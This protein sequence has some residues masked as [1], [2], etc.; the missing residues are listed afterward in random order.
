M[1]SFT[2]CII[3]LAARA[4][5]AQGSSVEEHETGSQDSGQNEIVLL[6]STDNDGTR[7]QFVVTADQLH[8][9]PE[10]NGK[11]EPPL[12]MAEAISL[13]R[14]EIKR[15]QPE[16]TDLALHR[17]ALARQVKPGVTNRWCYYVTF[18]ENYTKPSMRPIPV[19]LFLLD[20][21]IV[22]PRI[23][24]GGELDEQTRAIPSEDVQPVDEVDLETERYN[25]MMDKAEDQS[26]RYDKLLRRWETQ[27]D[28]LDVVLERWEK[29]VPKKQ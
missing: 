7:S 13:A 24:E 25:E 9:S 14:A 18:R 1:K 29:V 5:L 8:Q 2:F 21:T 11:D 28:R 20:G 3:C 4:V 26:D 19:V 6:T 23:L 17:I 22:T 10:W 27:A 16:Y 15:K 12:S